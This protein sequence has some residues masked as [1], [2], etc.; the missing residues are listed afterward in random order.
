MA[1][2]TEILLQEIAILR[3]EIAHLHSVLEKS[4]E[5][6]HNL[7]VAFIE[8]LDALTIMI[9]GIQARLPPLPQ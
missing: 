1:D 9:R 4:N 5:S 8:G 3:Q 2:Q 6:L 7:N